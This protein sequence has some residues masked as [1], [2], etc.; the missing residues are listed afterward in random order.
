MLGLERRQKIL[1]MLLKNQKVHVTDLSETF[2]VTP[3]TIRRDLNRLEKKGFLQRTYGG[4]LLFDPVKVDIP[5]T[6]R[7]A[8]NH[9]QKEKI[10]QKAAEL[11]HDGFSIMADSSTTV[12]TAIN[13]LQSR[14]KLTIITNS[15]KI[16]NDYASCSSFSLIGTGGSLR[17]HSFAFVDQSACNFL[18]DYNVDVALISCKGID[19]EK[20]IMES[21]EPE[22][23]VKKVMA[24]RARTK[25][26]LID[27][28]KFNQTVFFK[29]LDFTDIDYI[30]TDCA[31]HEE[32]IEFLSEND[33]ELIY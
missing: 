3:E 13:L 20:G 8:T 7:T 32:W 11:I 19:M 4:G 24:K 16:L 12:L 23:Y 26:L 25:I 2:N 33:V 17:A 5:F 27:H 30:V 21:N 28:A 10:A 29:A 9:E 6:G 15:I 22:A 18:D 1:E 14:K 31:P